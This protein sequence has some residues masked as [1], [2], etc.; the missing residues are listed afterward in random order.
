M[1][2][3]KYKVGDMV[4]TKAGD[5]FGIRHV[6]IE[7]GVIW[8][9]TGF[10]LYTDESNILHAVKII[11]DHG[12]V[13]CKD[14]KHFRIIYENEKPI[15]EGCMCLDELMGNFHMMNW[16]FDPYF[17]GDTLR[18]PPNCSCFEPKDLRAVTAGGQDE[19]SG[20]SG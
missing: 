6:K 17:S 5:I 20:N 8:Y 19:L 4:E 11:P 3:V 15:F 1:S 12:E 9:G 13:Y 7:D 2:E 16:R 18:P 14:C 10:G